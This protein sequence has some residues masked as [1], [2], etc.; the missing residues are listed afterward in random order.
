MTYAGKEGQSEYCLLFISVMSKL[1]GLEVYAWL[2]GSSWKWDRWRYMKQR[3]NGLTKSPEYSKWRDQQ[4]HVMDEK[5][6]HLCLNNGS[7]WEHL[8]NPFVLKTSHITVVVK[9][10]V[11]VALNTTLCVLW[12]IIWRQIKISGS[13]VELQF[14]KYHHKTFKINFTHVSLVIT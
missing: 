8:Q 4:I 11:Q 7:Q 10:N 14:K 5:K 2:G 6:K 12:Q 3:G 13:C 9:V 1:Q